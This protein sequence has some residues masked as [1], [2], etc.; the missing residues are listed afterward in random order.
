MRPGTK[1]KLA[2]RKHTLELLKWLYSRRGPQLEGAKLS[3]EHR[4]KQDGGVARSR[5]LTYGEV[6]YLLPNA[7]SFLLHTISHQPV[8]LD[9]Q[10]SVYRGSYGFTLHRAF[11]DRARNHVYFCIFEFSET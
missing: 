2:R 7:P 9:T 11:C 5:S 3:L 1:L 8:H 4:H 10:T 6:R